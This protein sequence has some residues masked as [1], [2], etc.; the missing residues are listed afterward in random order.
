[1]LQAKERAKQLAS[2][3][4][5][6]QVAASS[7]KK[8]NVALATE[9]I[10]KGTEPTEI[11]RSAADIVSWRVIDEPGWERGADTRPLCREYRELEE[12]GL[13]S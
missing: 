2:K 1:M 10:M 12:P 6:A 9:A 4:A 5:T 13:K 7:E 8:S 11:K 3:I